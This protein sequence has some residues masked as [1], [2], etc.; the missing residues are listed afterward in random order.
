MRWPRTALP[1]ERVGVWTIGVLAIG[2]AAFVGFAGTPFAAPEGSVER[3]AAAPGVE[4]TASHGGYAMR[5][6]DTA[7][8]TGLVFYPGARVDPSAYVPLLAPVVDRADVAVFVP[9]PRFNLAVFEP[10]MAGAVA[11]DNPGIQRWYV[12]GHSLG[13]AMACRYAS[14]EHEAVEGLVLFG[15][16]CDR[17][18]ADTELGVLA[19]GGTRD[20][21]IGTDR[22]ALKPAR[23]P[24]TASIH[25]I[26]GANH[27]SFGSY[28]GQRGDSPA[29]ISR[30]AAHAVLRELLLDF[31]RDQS[32]SPISSA[33]KSWSRDL[34][35]GSISAIG[36]PS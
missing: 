15:A 8:S 30:D 10:A 33:S 24:P 12:G 27:T 21:V 2:L 31:L 3:A 29:T 34:T 32:S 11:A 16:Y 13:G 22:E 28:A 1:W 17:S 20:T 35:S 14:N 25:R 19:V 7:P 9:R 6:T 26:E 4:I 23:L 18:I 36:S 5:P